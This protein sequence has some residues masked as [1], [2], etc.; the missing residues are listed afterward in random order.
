MLIWP[1]CAD[2]KRRI[3]P[4]ARRGCD[5]SFDGGLRPRTSR[6]GT[7]NGRA[8]TCKLNEALLKVEPGVFVNL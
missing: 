3:R 8:S 1:L 7:G 2:G 6:R 4:Q 5:H